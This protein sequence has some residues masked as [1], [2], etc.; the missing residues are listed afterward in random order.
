MNFDKPFSTA[1]R[2]R[3]IWAADYLGAR[4]YIGANDEIW[5]A[6]GVWTH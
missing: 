3:L 4:G 5:A 2:E 6:L 1:D